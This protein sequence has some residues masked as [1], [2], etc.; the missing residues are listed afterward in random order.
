MTTEK[1]KAGDRLKIFVVKLRI[2]DKDDPGR[3]HLARG[4]VI[5]KNDLLARAAVHATF[6]GR[7]PVI[8][9]TLE[10]EISWKEQLRGA[11]Q[12]VYQINITVDKQDTSEVPAAA[13][14]KQKKQKTERQTI[15]AFAISTAL[16][17]SPQ[18]REI[19]KLRAKSV[20]AGRAPT[21]LKI[22]EAPM[23]ATASYAAKA[24]SKEI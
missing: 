13:G 18:E 4:A 5:A 1:T 11:H 23:I 24:G 14:S 21:V 3:R 16:A 17:F 9:E 7:N 19:L 20:F 10:R 2:D 15:A 8:D 12:A 22:E 6:R